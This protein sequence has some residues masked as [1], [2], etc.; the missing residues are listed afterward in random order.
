MQLDTETAPQDRRWLLLLAAV[1]LVALMLRSSF[2]SDYYAFDDTM[3]IYKADR[4]PVGEVFAP[5]AGSIPVTLLS[6][7]IDRM[8]F[9]PRA[10]TPTV[11]NLDS[12]ALPPPEVEKSY[13]EGIFAPAL[14]I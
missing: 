12:D 3:Y 9:G 1:A 2:T 4:T 14:R 7:K 13:R 10:A 11:E 6:W 5:T 8:L